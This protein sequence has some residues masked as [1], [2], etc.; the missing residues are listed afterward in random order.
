LPVKFSSWKTGRGVGTAKVDPSKVGKRSDSK[1]MIMT[2]A[3]ITK[4]KT[5]PEK[6]PLTKATCPRSCWLV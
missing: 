4:S 1:V 6:E 2:K 3:Y 5:Q